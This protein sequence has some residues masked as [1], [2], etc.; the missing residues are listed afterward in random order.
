MAP[1][2]GKAA[3][4]WYRAALAAKLPT[5]IDAT[6]YGHV[7]PHLVDWYAERPGQ[8]VTWKPAEVYYGPG[9]AAGAWAVLWERVYAEPAVGHAWRAAVARADAVAREAARRADAARFPTLD[10]WLEA[11]RRGLLQDTGAKEAHAFGLLSSPR[12]TR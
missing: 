7:L 8:F 11:E 2:F 6:K 12:R 9:F 3:A 1:R 4:R 5:V 10:A